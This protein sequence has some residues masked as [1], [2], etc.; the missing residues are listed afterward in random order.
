MH[1]IAVLCVLRAIAATGLGEKLFESREA[2]ALA[3]DI[4]R[5]VRGAAAAEMV[6][7]ERPALLEPA[8]GEAVARTEAGVLGLFHYE[9]LVSPFADRNE[10]VRKPAEA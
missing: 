10:A 1:E 5:L 2:G 8:A 3:G 9:T 4:A 6:E 7:I